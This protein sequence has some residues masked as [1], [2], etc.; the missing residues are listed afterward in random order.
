MRSASA[1]RIRRCTRLYRSGE[2]ILICAARPRAPRARA[3]SISL[4]AFHP[5]D[6]ITPRRE[7]FIGHP[8]SPIYR[9][10]A[11]G[12]EGAIHRPGHDLSSRDAV[13]RIMWI[14]ALILSISFPSS[15]SGKMMDKKYPSLFEYIIIHIVGLLYNSLFLI[16]HPVRSKRDRYIL[17]VCCLFNGFVS[18]CGPR[19]VRGT[20]HSEKTRR[21]YGNMHI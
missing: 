4:G 21:I 18:R 17:S 6:R 13:T 16:L 14:T 10:A 20:L 3:R 12:A 11:E 8:C 15:F 9:I 2:Y 7:L 19:K 1:Y 5:R